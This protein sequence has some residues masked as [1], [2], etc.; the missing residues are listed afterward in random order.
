VTLR[1]EG[2]FAT[3]AGQIVPR[4][5]VCIESDE[6]GKITG[7]YVLADQL[8]EC[9]AE[10]AKRAA[11]REASRADRAASNAKFMARRRLVVANEGGE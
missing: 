2:G 6:S 4:H 9:L 3:A 7:N 11:A 8:A 5:L 10:E 1:N